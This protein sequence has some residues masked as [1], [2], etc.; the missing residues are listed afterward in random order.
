MKTVTVKNM[1]L[2]AGRTKIAV[3][4]VAEDSDGLMRAAAQLRTLD[5]DLAEFRADFLKRADEADF[6]LA[7]LEKVRE[8][9][10]DTPLLFTFR[11]A[12]ESKQERRVRQRFAH[13]FQLRQHKIRLVRPF[14]KI[15]AK[16]GQ[17]K[18]QSAQL[19]RRPHQAV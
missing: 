13:F 10:P 5:F 6:V 19:R 2:G 18:I 17:I 14:Q 7:Q 1:V 11:R 8:A 4:L 9:L 15:R 3:P 16:L 12:A